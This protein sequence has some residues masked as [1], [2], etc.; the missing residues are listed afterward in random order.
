MGE[1]LN[2]LGYHVGVRA[3]DKALFGRVQQAVTGFAGSDEAQ[4]IRHRWETAGTPA[5]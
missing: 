3:S 4:E 1:P 5:P 2:H